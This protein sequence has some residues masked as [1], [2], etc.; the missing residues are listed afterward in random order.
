M[1]TLTDEEAMQRLSDEYSALKERYWSLKNEVDVS[2]Y[3]KQYQIAAGKLEEAQ[4]CVVNLEGIIR[5]H[6]DTIKVLRVQIKEP[7]VMSL[8][9][10]TVVLEVD[11]KQI[12]YYVRQTTH[13]KMVKDRDYW[14]NMYNQTI[15]IDNNGTIPNE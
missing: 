6:K 15:K 1:I 10:G 4:K 11:K 9:E 3:A 12:G 5:E 13:E 14:R 8:P 2:G 7:V